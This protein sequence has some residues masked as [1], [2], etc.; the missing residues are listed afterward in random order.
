[1]GNIESLGQDLMFNTGNVF[2][3]SAGLVGCWGVWHIV[4]TVLENL[5]SPLCNLPGPPPE[6]LLFGHLL[7]LIYGEEHEILYQWQQ[8]YGHVFSMTMMLGVSDLPFYEVILCSF[9]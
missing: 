5:R 8:T 4:R 6:S 2:A 1:M 3:V 9:C 7:K